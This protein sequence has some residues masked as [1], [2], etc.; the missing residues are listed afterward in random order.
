MKRFLPLLMLPLLLWIA[1][2]DDTSAEET[3]SIN[4]TWKK[5]S[6]NNVPWENMHFHQWWIIENIPR[7][8]WYKSNE[9][10]I[11][12][13]S[14]ATAPDTCFNHSTTNVEFRQ[15][16]LDTYEYMIN[17]YDGMPDSESTEYYTIDK[18]T[19]RV[20][21]TGIDYQGVEWVT[22]KIWFRDN[23]TVFEPEC[24]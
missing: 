9:D 13:I 12:T 5:Y 8:A 10:I 17:W 2:E 21:E 15:S 24:E 19:L 22:N 20:Y 18:D 7:Y 16:D 1:C 23:H 6:V 4:G 11:T 3:Y 14:M